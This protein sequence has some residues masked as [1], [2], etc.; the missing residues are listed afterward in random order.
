M[1]GGGQW[2]QCRDGGSG[3]SAGAGAEAASGSWLHL[4]LVLPP[5]CLVPQPSPLFALLHTPAPRA[6]LPPYPSPWFVC[7]TAQRITP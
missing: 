4:L 6:F 5:V 2:G 7:L 1:E 3:S